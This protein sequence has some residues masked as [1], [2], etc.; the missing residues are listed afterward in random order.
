MT[1]RLAG[2]QLICL[3]WQN[4]LLAAAKAFMQNSASHKA[5]LIGFDV[6]DLKRG[7]TSHLLVACLS[8]PQ[9]SLATGSQPDAGVMG[10]MRRAVGVANKEYA[11][12]RTGAC[13]LIL[14]A[15]ARLTRLAVGMSRVAEAA[16]P[17]KAESVGELLRAVRE[18]EAKIHVQLEP[19]ISVCHFALLG[20][21]S[22]ARPIVC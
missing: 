13:L 18:C 8:A 2:E 19:K 21:H 17:T 9:R 11:Y 5:D 3:L 12:Q 1:V 16:Q 4:F 6:G 14:S 20:R 22:Q 10:F 15:P 7:A